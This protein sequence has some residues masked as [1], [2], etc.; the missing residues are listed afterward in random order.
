MSRV[1]AS[2]GVGR[3]LV[4][5]LVVALVLPVLPLLP[6][7]SVGAATR[8]VDSLSDGAVD[9]G[10]CTDAIAGNC[11]L[12][13]AIAA[14]LPN[15]TITFQS[16]FS[17]TVTL[18][19]ALGSLILAQNVT[20]TGPGRDMLFISGGCTTCGS[21]GTRSDGVRVLVVNS[22]VTATISGVT[23]TRGRTTATA[24]SAGVASSTTAR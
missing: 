18:T 15:D 14:A 1:R 17:G 6:V 8:I 7:P 24:A 21:G 12:R 19:A 20:I 23:I 16:G 9:A 10:H 5:L 2:V 4:A 22:N 3:W 11:T 13:D